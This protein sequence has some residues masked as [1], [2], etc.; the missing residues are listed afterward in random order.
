MRPRFKQRCVRCR[1]NMVIVTVGSSYPLCY[2][3]QKHELVGK[4]KDPKMKK[5]F[6]IPEEYYKNSLFL[7]SIKINYLKF[8]KLTDK[9]IEFFKKATENMKNERSA[10]PGTNT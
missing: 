1:K 2:D 9:Q 5:M 6:D 7:R 10:D 3:C 4:V 8:G